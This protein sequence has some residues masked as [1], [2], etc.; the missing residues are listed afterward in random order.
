MLLGI[1][2]VMLIV[3]GE[4]LMHVGIRSDR[5]KG[6]PRCPKCW[7]DMRGTLPRLVCPECG[8][9]ALYHMDLYLDR[10]RPWLTALGLFLMVSVVVLLLYVLLFVPA[11]RS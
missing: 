5:S 8:H 1:I 11:L 4:F 2:G 10:P 9:D 7:Y 6:R 3:I